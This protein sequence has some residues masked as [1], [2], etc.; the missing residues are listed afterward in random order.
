[1]IQDE[2]RTLLAAPAV[3]ADA[4]TL[5]ALEHTLTTGYAEALALDAQRSRLE[6]RISEVA[7][8]LAKATDEVTGSELVELGQRLSAADGDLTQLRDLLS[9]LRDRATRL[10][11]A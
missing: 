9:S 2:I 11:P 8:T 5:A 7:S 1:M 10:R 6:R 4:P 3:G